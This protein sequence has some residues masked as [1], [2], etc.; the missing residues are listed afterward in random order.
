ML[1]AAAAAAAK[2]GREYTIP[3]K[4]LHFPSAG[5]IILPSNP[6][7][8]YVSSLPTKGELYYLSQL[9]SNTPLPT[10]NFSNRFPSFN[11]PSRSTNSEPPAKKARRGMIFSTTNDW[12]S[13]AIKAL[14]QQ[15][16]GP[17]INRIERMNN[18]SITTDIDAG[19]LYIQG[20]MDKVAGALGM[21]HDS[22]LLAIESKDV[23]E[24]DL[25]GFAHLFL[26]GGGDNTNTTASSS[27]D[28]K[29]E[30]KKKAEKKKE[31]K[32]K[33][34]DLL[35][36]VS[37]FEK[38]IQEAQAS[39][40]STDGDPPL[41]SIN[42]KSSYLQALMLDIPEGVITFD[43]L[44]DV[45]LCIMSLPD[46]VDSTE[47]LDRAKCISRCIYHLRQRLAGGVVDTMSN[48]QYHH[49]QAEIL[50]QLMMCEDLSQAD[51]LHYRN[52]INKSAEFVDSVVEDSTVEAADMDKLTDIKADFDD[53]FKVQA[54][55]VYEELVDQFEY[56]H[57]DD[58]PCL[59]TLNAMYIDESI[60]NVL[61]EIGRE[62]PDNLCTVEQILQ[63]QEQLADDARGGNLPEE[64]YIRRYY[65]LRRE[66][67]D[68]LYRLTGRVVN[69]GYDLSAL[70]RVIYNLN[71]AP[72]SVIDYDCQLFKE[73][74]ELINKIDPN[75]SCPRLLWKGIVTSLRNEAGGLDD[76][77]FDDVSKYIAFVDRV[78]FVTNSNKTAGSGKDIASFVDI[79]K[80]VTTGISF[81]CTE[82]H[83]VD[84]HLS[85]C[86]LWCSTYHRPLWC[87]RS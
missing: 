75:S 17:S 36:N 81:Y 49:L 68:E 67:A 70:Y 38:L 31:K 85:Q 55:S 20:A 46:T 24:D 51:I 60:I 63:K 16:D 18:V 80:P 13:A 65:K 52:I 74:E 33:S 50:C 66:L 58:P 59:K 43:I 72:P 73:F 83:H 12:G 78:S 40:F 69:L 19:T 11:P 1:S 26:D 45:K 6:S 61:R 79:L 4:S 53:R 48:I 42:A 7:D 87:T 57:P 8:E 28:K 29:K 34:V 54:D 9:N 77:S 71:Y 21:C 35:A 22:V 30:E 82:Q 41:S 5:P 14:E 3:R 84:H 86:L 76:G 10:N 32:D 15:D 47:L 23:S 64:D 37:K 25:G 39:M 44:S 56:R 27:K 2:R 62:N